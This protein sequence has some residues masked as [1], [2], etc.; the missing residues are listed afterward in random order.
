MKTKVIVDTNVVV[1]ASVIENISELDVVIKHEFYDQSIQLF[2]LFKQDDDEVS[3]VLVPTV[4]TESYRI[5]SKAV[6]K[7]FAPDSLKDP[8]RRALFYNDAIAIITS[9]EQ[10]MRKLMERLSRGKYDAGEL[11]E[12]LKEVKEMSK[13]LCEEWKKK[14]NK[15]NW[16]RQ[17]S[18][19]R[20]RP[21]MKEP[22]TEEQKR[23]V[24]SAHKS[25]IA[26][27]SLQLERFTRKPN[28]QDEIILAE[29]ISV[30]S[31]DQKKGNSYQ[32][33]IASHDSGFFVPYIH[34]N[35]GVS[36]IVTRE[37]KQRFNI[38]CNYPR[39]IY[40]LFASFQ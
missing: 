4:E 13:H 32:Y 34:S 39:K 36:D 11:S 9:S 2:S 28:C 40:V 3:G 10:K 31:F 35:L 15:R 21:V 25:Q 8:R 7:V 29:T 5:L 22:W 12:N 23:E 38:E 20:A 14:Y 1:A 17:E 16:Q 6:R 37:I 27:E 18:K 24:V 30:R 19:T 26:R 33:Y